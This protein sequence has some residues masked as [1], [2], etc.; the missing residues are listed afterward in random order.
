MLFNRGHA[1]DVPRW[2][3]VFRR[4]TV[5]KLLTLNVYRSYLKNQL[6]EKSDPLTENNQ[7]FATKG[8][9]GTWFHV[10]LK[11]F[12]EIIKRK[13][14][15]RCEVISIKSGILPI[16]LWL[17]GRT[18]QKF[19]G[20]LLPHSPSLYQVLSKLS[21]VGTAVSENFFLTPHRLNGSSSPVLT[22]TPHSYGKG[23]NS[24]LYKIETPERILTK[25]DTVDYVPEICSQ[26]KF[27]GDR[28]S[29]GFWVNT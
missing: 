7:Y 8:F 16:S 19:K 29:G 15:N 17:L 1:E 11:S 12:A 20:L 5:F 21:S 27:G 25:F 24:T 10:F 6:L 9:T 13:C 22:A 26:T 23:Q 3:S 2:V 14:S 18:C 28:F 4:R